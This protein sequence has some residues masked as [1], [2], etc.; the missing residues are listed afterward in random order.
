MSQQIDWWNFGPYN[1][2]ESDKKKKMKYSIRSIKH[3]NITSK[4]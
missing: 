3:N 4:A 1:N 2:P